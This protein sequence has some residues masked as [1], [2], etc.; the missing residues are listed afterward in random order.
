MNIYLL[1]RDNKVGYD[2]YDGF[3]IAANTED[4]ARQMAAE[5]AADEGKN[6]WLSPVSDDVR[7][8]KIGINDYP[9]PEII[10]DSF[11]AG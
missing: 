3:V 4:E 6:I 10:L 9:N 2:E 5:E 11:N 7:V 1:K 8:V